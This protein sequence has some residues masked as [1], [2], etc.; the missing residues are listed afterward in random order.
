MFVVSLADSAIWN[1]HWIGR[2]NKYCIASNNETTILIPKTRS[3]LA[4]WQKLYPGFSIKIIQ[5]CMK[6]DIVDMIISASNYP[7]LAV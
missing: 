4:N 1:N 7:I 3:F 5:F 6:V 2:N